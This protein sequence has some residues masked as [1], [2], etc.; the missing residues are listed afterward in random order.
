MANYRKSVTIALLALLVTV[1]GVGCQYLPQHADEQAPA[2]P[3]VAQKQ[4]SKSGALQSKEVEALV[5]LQQQADLAALHEQ[6]LS[7]VAQLRAID[8]RWQA[9]QRTA[10]AAPRLALQ[11]PI[12]NMQ[13][14]RQELEDL[15][16]SPCVNRAKLDLAQS[17]DLSLNYMLKFKANDRAYLEAEQARAAQGNSDR[18][19]A[20]ALSDSVG[21]QLMRIEACKGAC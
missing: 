11:A 2:K 4:A 13:K 7:S 6:C 19:A 17:M 5:L 21:A 16:N 9:A 20:K 3:A 15:S 14:I 12:A 1:G 18:Q 8:V 10:D